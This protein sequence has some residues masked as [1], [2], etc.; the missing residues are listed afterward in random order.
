M[1]DVPNRLHPAAAAPPAPLQSEEFVVVTGRG[2]ASGQREYQEIGGT[3]RA[4]K[5]HFRRAGLDLEAFFEGTINAQLPIRRFEMRRPLFQAKDITW[6]AGYPGEN[7]DFCNCTVTVAGLVYPALIYYPRPET[8]TAYA[9]PT[10]ENM[11]EILA[12]FITSLASCGRGTLSVDSTQ[13]E[14]IY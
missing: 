1:R 3:I 9:S 6:L 12:P 5:P 11:V 7:F 8:K 2:A 14:F 4:Q 13:L 10:A